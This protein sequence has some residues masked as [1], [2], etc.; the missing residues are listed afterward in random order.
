[1]QP[2]RF[3]T[4][5]LAAQVVG[6]GC[7]TLP[8]CPAHGGPAWR[9]VISEHF[10]VRTD[11]APDDATRITR[12]LEESRA[13]M[14]AT[15][16]SNR[17]GPPGRIPVIALASPGELYAFTGPD[18]VGAWVHTPP[19]PETLIL[20][21]TPGGL[22]FAQHE[23]A[24][25]LG[26]WALPLQPDWFSDGLT[27][28][29]STLKVD[30]DAGETIVGRVPTQL[31]ARLA[32]ISILPLGS[33]F[34]PRPSDPRALADFE[35]TSWLLFEYLF[36]KRPAALARFQDRLRA[37]QRPPDAW[38]AEFGDLTQQR[39]ADELYEY[40]S[41]GQ[42]KLARF[43][44]VS[45]TAPLESRPVVDAEVHGLRA[46][47]YA[48]ASGSGRPA[49]DDAR[50]EVAEARREDPTSVGA[51]AVAFYALGERSQTDREARAERIAAAHPEAWMS[52]L[53]LADAS[54]TTRAARRTALTRALALAPDQPDVAAHF[55]DLKAAEQAW[56]EA[57]K[58]SNKA[59]RLEL[60]NAGTM[61]THIQALLH[62]GGCDEAMRFGD[63][64]SDRL[65][66]AAATALRSAI[67][68]GQARC[69]EVAARRSPTSAAP[70]AGE[71][72][73]APAR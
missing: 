66:A 70:D 62:T 31:M 35:A 24:H 19:F 27:W 69:T 22:E 5:V 50:R 46:F 32:R 58:F 53:M 10:V 73:P 18:I 43:P 63:A 60:L 56:D 25:Y 49:L 37:W 39:L 64:L 47:M 55:A 57:L 15:V 45:C 61:R 16:W 26:H 23:L 4:A 54:D 52:W 42:G 41:F 51:G 7:G 20:R 68:A 12:V 34:G 36:S 6:V 48:Y 8:A 14:L 44:A 71:E 59:V 67:S 21:D 40:K 1:M 17:P 65:D 9:E 38:A 29:L 72:L 28:F 2:G 33:L 30:H 13:A 3:L 11:L